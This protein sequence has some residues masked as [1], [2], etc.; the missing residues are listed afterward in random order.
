ML[1]LFRRFGAVSGNFPLTSTAPHLTS[2][3]F[4]ISRNAG[5]TLSHGAARLSRESQI[6]QPF[7]QFEQF[8]TLSKCYVNIFMGHF[9]LRNGDGQVS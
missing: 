5:I 7:E 3:S 4:S 8:L 2:A 1:E 9:I 6:A